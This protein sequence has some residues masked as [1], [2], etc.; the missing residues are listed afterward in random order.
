M[1]TTFVVLLCLAPLSA[2]AAEPYH[3][4]IVL[5]VAN[6]RTLT[7]VLQDRLERELGEGLQ[8]ALAGM[9]RVSVV[10]THELLPRI[11][12]EGLPQ[13]LAAWT[14]RG[15]LKTHF[16]F[17]EYADPYYQV[18]GLQHDG[19]TG[20]VGPVVRVKRT[21]DRDFVA[22]LAATLIE[23]DFGLTGKVVDATTLQLRGVPG[24]VWSRWVQPGDVFALLEANGE[25][26]P[27]AFLQVTEVPKDDSGR[28]GV[29]LVNRYDVPHLIGCQAIKLHTLSGP[30]RV[31]LVQPN[32]ANPFA[33]LTMPPPTVEFRTDS[34]AGKVPQLRLTPTPT[35]PDIYDTTG[36]ANGTFQ[37][38]AFVTV[39]GTDGVLA[40]EPVPILGQTEAVVPLLQG[41]LADPQRLLAVSWDR[42]VAEA[43]L[44][45][46]EMM[47]QLQTL[48]AQAEK[49]GETLKLARRTLERTRADVARLK[50][51]R[52]ALKDRPDLREAD[53]RLGKLAA[54]EPE[55]QAFLTRLEEIE[56]MEN[57][58]V[59]AEA[60]TREGE[61]RLFEAQG[62]LGK[63][64]AIYRA[65][66]EKKVLRNYDERIQELETLWEPK[67]D[68]HRA[69]R[70]F[71]FNVWGK[72]S[73]EEL[74][75]RMGAAQQ[76][77]EE[78]KKVGDKL[79]AKKLLDLADPHAIR[80]AKER[81]SVRPTT[82]AAE[83]ERLNAASTGLSKL[84]LEI[85]AFLKTPA[86]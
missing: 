77:F 45:Q 10:R 56:A 80:L 85:A 57:D 29:K 74:A 82:P 86:P 58:P 27:A 16:L 69:A 5:T 55:V 83:I 40:T 62:E 49:R 47:R 11:A 24:V 4:Q 38:L 2:R 72:L 22:R 36:R 26:I 28:C 34:F 50:R 17:I 25:P 66:N 35:S 78:C 64:L 9:A 73:T 31:R 41:P 1:R 63:A 37:H 76:A 23:E 3:L 15:T 75:S 67:N 61:A 68:A 71:I 39:L 60:K 7:D 44:V 65:L 6:Q 52:L 54:A 79:G 81:A 19:A 30:V 46:T 59:R 43:Y 8:A 70:E 33:A 20:Q 53:A 42:G 13:A 48:A 32:E 12:K 14:K 51:D 21:R 18:R 84:A